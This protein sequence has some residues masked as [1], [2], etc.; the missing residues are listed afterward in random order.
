MATFNETINEAKKGLKELLTADNTESVTAIDTLLDTLAAE[1]KKSSEK[2]GELQETIVK[3]VKGTAFN[4][5]E[6][7]DPAGAETKSLD[8]I[9]AS[10]LKDVLKN[11]KS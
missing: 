8:D 11:Q 2:I 6:D 3:Y 7:D 5:P 4:S 9:I 1:H 10:S